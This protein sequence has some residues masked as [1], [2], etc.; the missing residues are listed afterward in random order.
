MI[1]ISNLTGMHSSS[2]HYESTYTVISIAGLDQ[3]T[4][5]ALH[6]YYAIH[7]DLGPGNR[8]QLQCVTTLTLQSLRSFHLIEIFYNES[9]TKRLL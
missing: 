3:Q 8:K 1:H 7:I 2:F 9:L 5:S 6:V 4:I